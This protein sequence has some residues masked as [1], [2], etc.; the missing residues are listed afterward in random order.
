[1]SRLSDLARWEEAHF[2][3][4]RW[5]TWIVGGTA[6]IALLGLFALLFEMLVQPAPPRTVVISTGPADGAYHAFAMRYRAYLARYGVDLVLK[7]SNGSLDNL[8][9]LQERRDGVQVA[10]VQGGLGTSAEVPGIVTLGSMFYEPVW[11]FWRGK[12]PLSYVSQLRGKRV[13]VGAEG[14]GTRVLATRLLEANGIDGNTA[15][16][17]PAGGLEAAAKLESGAVD[18]AILVNAPEA[19]AVQRLLHAKGVWP[20]GF[21]RADAYARHF[22][23]LEKLVIP[24]GALDLAGNIP[25][26]DLTVIAVTANL[27]AAS[28]LHPVIVDLLL[29]AA[30]EVHGGSSL[31][32][33]PGEFPSLRDRDFQPSPDA[34]RSYRGQYTS[35]LRH[36]MPFWLSV[37]VQRFLFFAI[38][39]LAIGIPLL[40]YLPAT[41]RWGIRRRIYRWYGELKFLELDLQRDGSGVSHALKRLDEIEER[42]NTLR[43]P[44]AYAGEYYHLRTHIGMVRH[45]FEARLKE[46]GS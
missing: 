28:D 21:R 22:P 16:L 18:A 12:Q 6:A 3:R 10:L 17:D 27:L 31:L 46:R 7:E 36:Y 37:W 2:R 15:R 39:V 19:L 29:E 35:F 4:M 23:Y 5:L 41:Y 43:V 38:P 20:I 14:S 26:Q 24:A 25:P 42:V 11:F 1:M 33:R 40:R 9:R 30:R 8:G 32:N 34:E 44:P 45:Q 13:A